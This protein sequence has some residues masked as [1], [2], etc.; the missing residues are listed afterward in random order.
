M[1]KA[2]PTLCKYLLVVTTTFVLAFVLSQ[3]DAEAKSSAAPGDFASPGVFSLTHS[4]TARPWP[5]EDGFPSTLASG[6]RFAA[7]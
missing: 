5:A 3:E 7:K 1:K 2:L 6:D 4:E